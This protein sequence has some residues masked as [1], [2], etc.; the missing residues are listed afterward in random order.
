MV[1]ISVD[2]VL[3]DARTSARVGSA[4]A[5]DWW[6]DAAE[7]G[8]VGGVGFGWPAA[9]EDWADWAGEDRRNPDTRL[10]RASNP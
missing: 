9:V 8:D 1:D 3:R 7:V 5:G 6:T 2:R 10:S 4:M